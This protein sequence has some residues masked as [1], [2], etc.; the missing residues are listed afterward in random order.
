MEAKRNWK[1]EVSK[2]CW[3]ERWTWNYAVF[4]YTFLVNIYCWFY[5]SRFPMS[6][7]SF[8]SW[9]FSSNSLPFSLHLVNI[10]LEY[11]TSFHNLL[12]FFIIFISYSVSVAEIISSSLPIFFNYSTFLLSTYEILF[13]S[14]NSLPVIFSFSSFM[15]AFANYSFL[16]PVTSFTHRLSF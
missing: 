4:D 16:L 9:Y 13:Y 6:S 10:T 2:N 8:M 15:A 12:V 7:F 14:F 11:F 3:Q 1:E 5:D